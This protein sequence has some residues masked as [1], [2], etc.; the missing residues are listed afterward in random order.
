MI[1]NRFLWLVFAIIVGAAFLSVGSCDPDAFTKAQG[2]G[3][4]AG[5][6]I[7][8][9]EY[10]NAAEFIRITTRGANI[11]PMMTETQIWAH[12]A[13]LHAAD[14]AGIS[15]S[16]DELNSIIKST[17]AFQNNGSFSRSLFEQ[18]VSSQLGIDPVVYREILLR[19]NMIL[20][21]LAIALAAG[22]IV[23][24]AEAQD[25]VNF[26]SDTVTFQSASVI[27]EFRTKEYESKDE[28]LRK[29][30]EAH[31]AEYKVDDRVAASFAIIPVSNY[32]AAVAVPEEDIETYYSNNE[33]KYAV[34]DDAGN[35][36]NR[37]LAEVHEEIRNELALVEAN[38]IA[39]T[40][41]ASVIAVDLNQAMDENG[42]IGSLSTKQRAFTT[43]A[44]TIA[45][46]PV[47][48]TGLVS[49]E[50]N[51]FGIDADV[52]EEFKNALHGLSIFPENENIF[53][54][55]VGE[56]TAYLL[57]VS[58]NDIARELTFDEVKERV[59][60][61]RLNELRKKDFTDH[62]EKLAAAIKASMVSNDFE[63]AVRALSLNVSTSITFSAETRDPS[64]GNPTILQ[65]ALLQPEKT[66]SEAVPTYSGA[67]F[68]YVH[69][70]VAADDGTRDAILKEAANGSSAAAMSFSE[71]M[72][73]NLEHSDVQTHRLTN[74]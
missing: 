26:R 68:V 51:I 70:R 65:A 31:K 20:N 46:Y 16:T 61:A 74:E 59:A 72:I 36:T 10:K 60:D 30:Y 28:D 15:V 45:K 11:S 14:K 5:K 42:N 38:F 40:N 19:D 4:I 32:I 39:E 41:L 67:A 49:T 48:E 3:T 58:T 29:Y 22:N 9:N 25:I 2:E 35:T 37:P 21:K 47:R 24:P 33:D 56:K 66:L 63:N 55:V 8:A 64:L 57:C 62:T 69:K 71:W 1:R 7:S 27:D 23:T 52:A 12:I 44:R 13:A 53:A 34:T 43:W 6:S 50:D 73:W 17:P 54:S 18:A